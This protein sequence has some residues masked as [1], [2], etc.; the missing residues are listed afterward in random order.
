MPGGRSVGSWS[1]DG[2]VGVRAMQMVMGWLH[3]GAAGGGSEGWMTLKIPPVV[4]VVGGERNRVTVAAVERGGHTEIVCLV[5]G[6]SR[7]IHWNCH[8]Y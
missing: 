6:Q 3:L 1:L 8:C 2:E 7:W 5:A 4:P